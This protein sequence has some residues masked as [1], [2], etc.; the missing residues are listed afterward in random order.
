MK[1]VYIA[2]NGGISSMKG[3]PDRREW[4]QSVVSLPMDDQACVSLEIF[5]SRY[6]IGHILKLSGSERYSF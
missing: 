3:E 6:D 4:T 1:Q 2:G 5:L